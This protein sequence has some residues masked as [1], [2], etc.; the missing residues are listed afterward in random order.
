MELLLLLQREPRRGWSVADL[1]RELRGS[2]QLVQESVAAL[3][4]AGLIAL[5]PTSEVQYSP[6]SAAIAELVTALAELYA[7]KPFT[8]LRA[9]FTSPSDKIRSFSDAFRFKKDDDR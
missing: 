7:Q 9:I 4:A 5:A 1:V 3:D 2:A 8:V 6:R